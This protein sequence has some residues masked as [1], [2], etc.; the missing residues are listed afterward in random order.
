MNETHGINVASF[1]DAKDENAWFTFPI[2]DEPAD[3]M[4][5][6]CNVVSEEH[7]IYEKVIT[8]FE[9]PD[10]DDDKKSNG[11]KRFQI[12]LQTKLQQLKIESSCTKK[13]TKKNI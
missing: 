6:V 7:I 10:I 11:N 5:V 8:P 12:I 3:S 4:K 13:I 1:N 2:D 9:F